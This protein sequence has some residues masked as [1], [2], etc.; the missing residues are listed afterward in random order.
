M[1]IRFYT[2]C[3][4]TPGSFVL[5]GPEAHHLAQ[6]CRIRAGEEVVLFNGDGAEYPAVVL[7]AQRKAVTLE[8]LRREPADRELGFWLEVAAPLPKGDRAQFLIEKLTEIGVSRF[9][10]LQTERSVVLPRDAKLEKLQR[11]VLEASKQCRRN[12]LMEIASLTKLSEYCRQLHQEAR[13]LVAHP[14]TQNDSSVLLSRLRHEDRP[15]RL[16]LV[17]GPEGGFTDD[18]I[19]SVVSAGCQLVDLGPRI[20]RVETAAVVLAGWWSQQ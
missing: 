4:L 18:E 20:L 16:S 2:N 14:S 12:V 13:I 10:P 6:V 9:V 7:S 3:P 1:S 19:Q 8:V 11:Y 5:Q 17:F 15:K